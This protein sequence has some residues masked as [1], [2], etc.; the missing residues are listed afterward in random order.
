M[1]ILKDFKILDGIKISEGIILG[2]VCHFQEATHEQTA[3]FEVKPSQID[4]E[5]KKLKNA[6]EKSKNDLRI[7]AANIEKT[8]GKNEAMIF[9][10]HELILEDSVLL[11]KIS[12]LIRDKFLNVEYSV[13]T[14]F[15]EYEQIFENMNNE[16]MRERALD[17]RELKKRILSYFTGET[18]KFKCDVGSKCLHKLERIVLA[19]EITPSLIARIEDD[20]I[21]GL[22]SE[23]GGVNSHAGIM[24]RSIGIPFVSGLHIVEQIECGTMVIVDGFAGKVIINPTDDIIHSYKIKDLTVKR[25][26]KILKLNKGPFVE[27]IDG[28]RIEIL[29]NVLAL[30]DIEMINKY[31]LNGIGLLRSEFMFYDNA[32]F[33]NKLEQ[34]AKYLEMIAHLN[35][36]TNITVRL[37]DFGGDK[38]IDTLKFENETNPL[39]GM[40]GA[41]YLLSNR[42]ILT[43]QL[44]AISI[45][46]KKHNINILY[47]MITVPD[48]IDLINSIA[49]PIFEQYGVSGN[50][51]IGVMF[52]VPSAFINPDL[53]LEKV[54][55]CSI[56]TNDLMQ[57]L[58]AVDRENTSVN[59]L[60]SLNNPQVID[61]IRPVIDA[62]NRMNKPI[63]LCGEISDN[64]DFLE[65]LIQAGL[66]KIS[67]NPGS[68]QKII[69]MIKYI[70]SKSHLQS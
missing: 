31:S 22:I 9:H 70:K 26:C 17:F 14:I 32:T 8:V 30:N 7:I 41:R 61:I 65:K 53:Y 38:K 63:S 64:F 52:E 42:S 4:N 48:E 6:L 5:I 34:S 58:F 21:V 68:S 23:K 19:K 33:P 62:A 57:Y 27:T 2:T 47:P 55:F 12:S 20:K 13:K 69:Q 50:I 1:E 67:V 56:G 43:E 3:I 29:G 45:V 37:F 66:R 35:S 24:A 11:D 46:A 54:D 39:L 44:E 40:R 16:Y 59:H 60:Y 25:E 18:G 28:N 49:K 51:K 36:K 10:S 15:E